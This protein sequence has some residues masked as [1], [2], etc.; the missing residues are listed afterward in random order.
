MP[1]YEIVD[2]VSVMTSCRTP[3][4]VVV[5]PVVS[6]SADYSMHTPMFLDVKAPRVPYQGDGLG[7]ARASAHKKRKRAAS[8]AGPSRD[9]ASAAGTGDGCCVVY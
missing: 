2:R 8:T 4:V 9:D 6:L 3:S 5:D 1:P 7:K